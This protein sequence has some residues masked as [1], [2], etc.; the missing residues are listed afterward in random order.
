MPKSPDNEICQRIRQLRIELAGPRGKS[1]FARQLGLSPS[2]YDYYEN[3][4]VP[5]AEVLVTI[6]DV[7][8][9]DLRWLLT[10]EQAS[11]DQP[12]TRHPV[13]RR[14]A[15]LIDE[16]PRAAEAL[17]A[18]L[19]LLAASLQFPEKPGQS[20]QSAPLAD[21]PPQMPETEG[22]G[23]WI[24]VL[25]RSAAGVPQFW[26]DPREE[27]RTTTLT[28]LIA[29]HA[30]DVPRSVR[31]ADAAGDATDAQ[32]QLVTL[33]EPDASGLSEF[34]VAGEV[35]SQ[36]P[37]AFA[38]RIDGESMSPEIRHGELVLLSP[39][40]EAV[41]GRAAVVQLRGQI[42]VTCKLYRRVDRE[43]HLVPINEAVP[44]TTVPAE[45]VVWA[46][47]V[48]ARIRPQRRGSGG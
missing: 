1:R 30:R 19:D 11:T 17:A 20:A 7:A 25:G 45:Q 42:G 4:R 21:P 47:K 14:A 2:T 39:A 12:L 46:L 40:V 5:P 15:K 35:K 26:A 31:P 29:R 9:V 41:D 38:V 43:V 44:P 22:P 10:G 6:A 28:E 16:H 13:V 8:G 48:L 18:F 37:D 34:V 32:A 33:T 23:G 3:D 36:Y 24:P 27:L